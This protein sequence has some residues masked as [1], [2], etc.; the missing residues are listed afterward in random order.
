LFLS[1]SLVSVVFVVE[2]GLGWSE[3]YNVLGGEPLPSLVNNLS[4]PLLNLIAAS[5]YTE[6]FFCG[7]LIVNL[8]E[9]LAV[10]RDRFV[11]SLPT[12]KVEGWKMV[13]LSQLQRAPVLIAWILATIFYLVYY[14]NN[15]PLGVLV[16][17]LLLNLIRA[18]FVLTLPF[19]LTRNL[20]MS[21]GLA[22]GWS[23]MAQ[24]IYGMN[25]RWLVDSEATVLVTLPTGPE[26]LTGSQNGLEAGFLAMGA[27]VLIGMLNMVWLRT[28]SRVSLSE[29]DRWAFTYHP[30]DD[31][32]SQE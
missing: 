8:S 29:R 20:G 27:I 10:I 22:L 11:P 21:I 17:P 16:L 6:L 14:V 3:I 19:I 1:V 23:F 30:F 5:V 31:E 4:L 32:R 25:L 13:I 12:S 26:L 15:N 9:G 18:S 24:N 7:Y 28:R 2:Y